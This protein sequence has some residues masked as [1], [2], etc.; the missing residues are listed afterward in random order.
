MQTT[1]ALREVDEEKVLDDGRKSTCQC[2]V[3]QPVLCL[4][5]LRVMNKI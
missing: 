2:F 5:A 4:Q 1:V 3:V